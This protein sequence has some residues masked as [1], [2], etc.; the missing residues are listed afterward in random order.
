MQSCITVNNP[1]VMSDNYRVGLDPYFLA[2]IGTILL[3]QK[4][5]V[6]YKAYPELDDT[7]LQAMYD[8][9]D[10]E[11]RNYLLVILGDNGHQI[12]DLLDGIKSK[13]A[14]LLSQLISDEAYKLDLLRK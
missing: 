11:M 5:D 2:G 3:K 9:G 13:D 12:M 4:L 7:K 6:F 14:H 8:S 10:R 1:Y